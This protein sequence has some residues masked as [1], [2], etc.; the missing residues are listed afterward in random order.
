MHLALAVVGF[1]AA[2]IASITG[3]NSLI[4]VP[5]MRLARMAPGK[6]R[7]FSRNVAV[8]LAARTDQ[9]PAAKIRLPACT[10]SPQSTP[11][12]TNAESDSAE[13]SE[14]QRRDRQLVAVE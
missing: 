2:L 5:A 12:G 6:V 9:L 8:L 11:M 13:E 7:S 10:T 3:G 14:E 4:T 1:V